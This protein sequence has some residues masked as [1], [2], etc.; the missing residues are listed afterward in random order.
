MPKTQTK[1]FNFV[2]NE[3]SVRQF[4]KHFS[5]EVWCDGR[6]YDPQTEGYHPVYSYKIIANDGEWE[7]MDNDIRGGRNEIPNLNLGSQSLFSFLIAC[8][9]GLP[10]DTEG[11][12]ENAELFP[13]HVRE[14]AYLMKEELTIEYSRLAME[15]S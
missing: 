14:F 12:S 5:I 7:Y 4:Q 10:E 6:E 11:K 8:Q 15:E 3:H 2:F 13:P 1:T 9:E